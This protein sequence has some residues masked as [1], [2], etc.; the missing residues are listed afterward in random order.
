MGILL[1]I[2]IVRVGKDEKEGQASNGSK[3]DLAAGE[4]AVVADTVRSAV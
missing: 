2:R 4:A 3:G 1:L